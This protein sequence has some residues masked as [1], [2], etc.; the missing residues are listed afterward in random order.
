ML[1][2]E[3]A[4]ADVLKSRAKFTGKLCTRVTFQKTC[5]SYACRSDVCNFIKLMTPAHLLSCEFY[6]IF[7]NTFFTEHHWATASV[8]K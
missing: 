6:K 3:A 4:V 8:N 2:T 5:R 7:K 1:N